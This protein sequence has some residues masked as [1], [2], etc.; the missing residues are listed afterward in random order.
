MK[1]IPEHKETV[2]EAIEKQTII[3]NF[4]EG[5][6]FEETIA[7]NNGL[8]KAADVIREQEW[9]ILS[10]KFVVYKDGSY[11]FVAD[12]ITWEYENDKNWLVTINQLS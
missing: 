3:P 12:G 7:Y 9:V 4:Q 5:G 8:K 6:R 11:K 1:S 2:L 10:G